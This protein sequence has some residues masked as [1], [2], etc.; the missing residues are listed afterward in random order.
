MAAHPKAQES[1]SSLRPPVQLGASLAA[2][3]Q[4]VAAARG[5]AR[6]LRRIFE[7]S[8]IPMAIVDNDRRYLEAN[9]AARLLL[10]M[11]LSELR[12]YRI[13]D[14]TPHQ[15][16]PA[17]EAAWRD[18]VDD[19]SS[20]GSIE[21]R[22]ADGS[23]LPITYH[24][25]ANVLPGRHLSVFAPS[26]WPEHELGTP[27]GDSE[28]GSACPLSVR[29]REVLSLVAT[30]ADLQEIADELTISPATVR[31]HIANVHRKLGTRNRAHAV[32]IAL[33]HGAIRP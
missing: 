13:D 20:T 25:L 7:S 33:Q 8:M 31:T 6:Q 4:T 18:L 10:R 29:E 32:A 1:A 19:A 16:L 2:T 5:R 3:A 28:R 21:L 12:R 11:R 15:R 24:R 17:L 26:H 14:F 30:G 27:E 22:L 23:R 9:K